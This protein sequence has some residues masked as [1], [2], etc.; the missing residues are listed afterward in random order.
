M[1]HSHTGV[2]LYVFNNFTLCPQKLTHSIENRRPIQLVYNHS[3][4]MRYYFAIILCQ[5]DIHKCAWQR[6]IKMGCSG[7]KS[8]PSS[9]NQ[10][11]ADSQNTNNGEK[12]VFCS[13]LL[14]NSLTQ[15]SALLITAFLLFSAQIRVRQYGIS[16]RLP[17]EEA[18]IHL[19]CVLW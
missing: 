16:L 1:T 4:I 11:K 7:S 3:K 8:S 17:E 19:P 13:A 5:P 9:G 6:D 10:P 2:N 14:A 15:F 12:Q 18:W